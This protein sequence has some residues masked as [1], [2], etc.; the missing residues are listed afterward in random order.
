MYTECNRCN[1]VFLISDEQLDIA[2]GK[3]RC[4]QCQHVFIA[5]EV[6]VSGDKA[7]RAAADSGDQ[8]ESELISVDS[9]PDFAEPDEISLDTGI[10]DDDLEPENTRGESGGGW[11]NWFSRKRRAEAKE[12]AAIHEETQGFYAEGAG[13]EPPIPVGEYASSQHK[14]VAEDFPYDSDLDRALENYDSAQQV[15]FEDP[16]YFGQTRKTGALRWLLRSVLAL[17]ALAILAAAFFVQWLFAD[18]QRFVS[19]PSLQ[20]YAIQICETVGCEPPYSRQPE[21]IEII[22]RSVV[23]HPEIDNAL[24]VTAKLVNQA[25]LPQP[26]PIVELKLNGLQGQVVALRRFEPSEYLAESIES[27]LMEAGESVAMRL[28]ILDP[29]EEAVAFQFAFY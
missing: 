21:R 27:G 2:G 15:S 3:V 9:T 22:E 10:D 12:A 16:A 23:S 6:V 17:F 4:G 14:E 26:L 24:L 19:F 7:E 18:T 25:K 13:D 8:Q 28:E 11:K 1:A 5:K 20:A 29:G